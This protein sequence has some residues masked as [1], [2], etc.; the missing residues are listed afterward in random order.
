MANELYPVAGQKIYIGGVISIGADDLVESDFDSQSWTEIDGWTQHGALGDAAALITTSLINRNRDVKQKGTSNAGSMQ[1]VFAI[2][3]GDPGQEAFILAAAPNEKRNFAFRV[4]GNDLPD[5]QSFVVTVSSATPGVFTKVAHGL[6]PRTKLQIANSGGAL[7]TGLTALTDY[8][9]K[10]VLSADTFTVSLTP[11][12]AAVATSSTGTGTH[13]VTT[14]PTPSKRL[15]G[16]IAMSSQEQG[17][18]ANTIR[19]MNATVEVNSNIVKVP[20][21]A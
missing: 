13:T 5:A 1:N 7:P 19:N 16:A 12:G 6:E 15:F 14:V 10:T 4:D 17:G 9:V 18:E 21:R 3:D 8:Y 2:V 11:G 20:A